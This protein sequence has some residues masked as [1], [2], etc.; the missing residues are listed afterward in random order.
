[1]YFKKDGDLNQNKVLIFCKDV[2]KSKVALKNHSNPKLT[3]KIKN[4]KNTHWGFASVEDHRP[5]M[6]EKATSEQ[7]LSLL[8]LI[9]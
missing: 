4:P 6:R 8:S 7:I 9:Q 2:T 3:K 1:M 5:L